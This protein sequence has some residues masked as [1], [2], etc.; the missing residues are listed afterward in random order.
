MHFDALKIYFFSLY[1]FLCCPGGTSPTAAVGDSGD[2]THTGPADNYSI[3][4]ASA[5]FQGS[6]DW[7]DSQSYY[8]ADDTGSS[9]SCHTTVGW[10]EDSSC[11]K[12]HVYAPPGSLQC[13]S[14]REPESFHTSI[15]WRYSTSMHS[16]NNLRREPYHNLHDQT[17]RSFRSAEDCIPSTSFDNTRDWTAPEPFQ[18][19]HGTKQPR[20]EVETVGKITPPTMCR[21]KPVGE[22]DPLVGHLG[23]LG[24]QEQQG[25]T[26]DGELQLF[27]MYKLQKDRQIEQ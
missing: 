25:S 27:S 19:S 6:Y 14:H 20:D 1:P 21:R 17:S 23:S 26:S 24:L 11:N 9:A 12:P 5:S 7:I 16:S 13:P 18:A 15:D 8:N 2:W 22:Y 4:E 3:W 10:A